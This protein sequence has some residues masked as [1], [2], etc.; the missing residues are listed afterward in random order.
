MRLATSALT[1][2]DASEVVLSALNELKSSVSAMLIIEPACKPD[3]EHEVSAEVKTIAVAIAA[4]NF[5]KTS[6]KN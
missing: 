4:K 3:E 1:E 6:P 2:S 5:F